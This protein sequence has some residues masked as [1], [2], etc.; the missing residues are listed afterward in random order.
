MKSIIVMLV[1][2]LLISTVSFAQKITSDKV[3]SAV[4]KAFKAKFPKVTDAKWEIE[5]K[6]EYEATFKEDN[7]AR[8]ASFDKDGKWL[9]TETIIEVAKLPH[10]VSETIIKNF[11]GYKIK[12]ATQLEKPGNANLYE[13][14]LTKGKKTIEVQLKPTGE[15]V[16]KSVETDHDDD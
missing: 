9:E 6:T 8:S 10:E 15:I 5:D 7:A 14:E 11:P 4:Q 13:V 3:P 12:E 2:G 16:N 1:A